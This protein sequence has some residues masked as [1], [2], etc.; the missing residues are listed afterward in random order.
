MHGSY[1][2]DEVVLGVSTRVI[3]SFGF[4][5]SHWNNNESSTIAEISLRTFDHCGSWW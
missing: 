1:R 5:C 4:S 2:S 3:G